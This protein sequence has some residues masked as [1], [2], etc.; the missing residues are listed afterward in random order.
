MCTVHIS[1]VYNTSD[2]FQLQ[3]I[4]CGW[5]FFLQQKISFCDARVWHVLWC[6]FYQGFLCFIVGNTKV[7]G[8]FPFHFFPRRVRRLPNS[9][10]G[11]QQFLAHTTKGTW[12]VTAVQISWISLAC[13]VIVVITPVWSLNWNCVLQVKEVACSSEPAAFLIHMREPATILIHP[14]GPHAHFP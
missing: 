11:K 8:Y 1:E 12:K 9:E 14:R 6:S 2:L 7:Q 3:K 4:N 5:L 10:P 13:T